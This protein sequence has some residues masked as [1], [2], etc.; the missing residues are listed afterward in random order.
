MYLPEALELPKGNPEYEKM[1]KHSRAM[2]EAYMKSNEIKRRLQLK[3]DVCH[4]SRQLLTDGIK[5]NA[6]V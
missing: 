3:K 2:N 1:K 5:S 4:L 6:A